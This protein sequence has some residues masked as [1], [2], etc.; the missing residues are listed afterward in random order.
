VSSFLYVYR[1][2]LNLLSVL[3]TEEVSFGVLC[4]F[5][6]QSLEKNV[7]MSPVNSDF[8]RRVIKFLHRSPLFC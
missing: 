7:K 6:C 2:N 4:V 8:Y 5:S 3:S 1:F